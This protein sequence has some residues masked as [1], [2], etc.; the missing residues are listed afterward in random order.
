M[1]CT[2]C[3]QTFERFA[4]QLSL[5]SFPPILCCPKCATTIEEGEFAMG[6]TFKSDYY[7]CSIVLHPQ[8]QQTLY[9]LYL[10][11]ADDRGWN[12]EIEDASF[13]DE[14]NVFDHVAY[15][16]ENFAKEKQGYERINHLFE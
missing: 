12:P 3:F 6:T 1:L 4:A 8:E 15:H 11:V 2:S 14:P 5:G 10:Q 9:E 13:I 7:D 16:V